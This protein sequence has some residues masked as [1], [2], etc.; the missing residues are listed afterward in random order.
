MAACALDRDEFHGHLSQ[1]KIG[2]FRHFT[3]NHDRSCLAFKGIYSQKDRHRSCAR[4][5][6]QHDVDAASL[7]ISIMRAS[8]SCFCTSMTWSAPRAFATSRRALSLD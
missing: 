3:L 6:V 4:R 1:R 7:V 5:T 8:G 2:E